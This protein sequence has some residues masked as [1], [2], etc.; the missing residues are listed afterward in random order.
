MHLIKIFSSN[1]SERVEKDVVRAC[2][3]LFKMGKNLESHVEF[4]R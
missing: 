2:V 1:E 3:F 4:N